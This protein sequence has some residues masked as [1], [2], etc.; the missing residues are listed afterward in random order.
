MPQ[1]FSSSIGPGYSGHIAESAA[2]TR[3]GGG[4]VAPRLIDAL[5]IDGRHGLLL[6]RLDGSDMLAM[7]ERQPWRLLGYARAL[8]E[9]Q[10]RIHSVQAP[11]DLPDVRQTL[12]SRIDAAPLRPQ[13]HYFA[14]RT[15]DG[16]PAMCWSGPIGGSVSSTGLTPLA[17]SPKPTMRQRCCCWSTRTLC[18]AH[19]YSFVG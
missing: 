18:P 10:I 8:A 17:A 14:R 5:E 19:R 15:L 9:G 4:G 16:L 7:L 2:L 3:L 13:L 6:E 1:R 12:A 11:A